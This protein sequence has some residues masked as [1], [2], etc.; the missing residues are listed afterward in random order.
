MCNF[1]KWVLVYAD[2]RTKSKVVKPDLFSESRPKQKKSESI[3]SPLSRLN[4][5][6]LA[7]L[8]VVQALDHP[9]S[10]T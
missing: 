1:R 9:S 10:I 7:L 8:V 3:D 2:H 5:R 4:E 6:T